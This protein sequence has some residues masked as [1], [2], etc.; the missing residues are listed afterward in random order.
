MMSACVVGGPPQYADTISYYLIFFIKTIVVAWW[1]FSCVP[2][3]DVSTTALPGLSELIVTYYVCRP[4]L[5]CIFRG[6][7]VDIHVSG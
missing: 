3:G 1:H 2:G 4:R 6:P 7:G 5:C